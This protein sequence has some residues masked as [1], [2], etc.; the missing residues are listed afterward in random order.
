MPSL[1]TL[2]EAK[3]D[4]RVLSLD[5]DTQIG[6]MIDQA[7]DIVMG[8]IKKDADALEWDAT[9]V[10]P[11]V[12]SAVSLVLQALFHRSGEPALS[13]NVKALLHRDRDPALA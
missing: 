1:M 12:K 7:S 11:R 9:T 4:L 6:Q 2:E 5:E 10:P 8:Y 3:R 13:D